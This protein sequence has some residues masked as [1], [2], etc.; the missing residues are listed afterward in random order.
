MDDAWVTASDGHRVPLLRIATVETQIGQPQIT[1]DNLK[2]MIPVT[3]RISGRDLGSTIADVRTAL[4]T[5]G[6]LPTD[7]YFELGGLYAEQQKAF[8]GLMA[9]FISAV[10]LVFVVLLYLYER[11][12]IALSILLMPLLAIAAVFLGLWAT[13]TELNITAMMGLT[14]I[15]GI[16]TEVSI[17]YFSEYHE[18][19]AQGHAA[20]GSAGAGGREPDAPDP[21]DDAD[22]D[23]R[24]VAVGVGSGSR[25]G[26]AAAARDRNHFGSARAGAVGADSSACVIRTLLSTYFEQD[27]HMNA[28]YFPVLIVAAVMSAGTAVADLPESPKVVQQIPGP[29]GGWD[30][31]SFDAD[32]HRV[33]ISRSYGVMT[34]DVD[35]SSVAQLAEGNRVHAS[36][37]L[38]SGRVLITNGN[39]GTTTLANGST[40]AIEATIPVGTNPDAAIYDPVSDRVFV[41]NANSGDISVID[42][43]LGKEEARIAVGGKLE[44][45]AV[46]GKGLLFVNIEDAA[47]VAVID[48]RTHTSSA[49]SI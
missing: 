7:A 27:I 46:D 49:V 17:F 13:G 28:N 45:A 3:A 4:A 12:S 22:G 33:L 10:M 38:P 1:R 35:D 19:T 24:A 6:L 20:Y 8:R 32:H 26:H 15:V 21:D 14:M 29:D 34:V 36:F 5:P 40:G 43:T 25:L 2:T 31:A 48:T 30:Y 23:P 44:A 18:L 16:V 42:T 47:K 9:V 37:V 39:T 41:M 11:F